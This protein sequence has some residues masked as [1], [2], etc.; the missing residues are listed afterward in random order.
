MAQ[1]EI[2]RT[3]AIVLRSL[4]YGETSQIVTLFTREKG[5]ITVMA[6]GARRT[7]S[8]FGATL[9]LMAYTQVVFYYKPG[10]NLQTLSESA[11]VEPLHRLN[12]SLEKISIGLRMVELVH[13]LLEKEDPQPSVFNLTQQTLRRLNA[14]DQRAA[15]LW[16]FFQ[17]R[18]ATQLGMAPS[19][20]RD[21]VNQVPERGGILDLESGAVLPPE[22]APRAG[23]RASRSALRAYAIFARAALDDVVR[24]RLRAAVRREV[25]DLISSYMRYQFE[26]AYPSTS[27]EVISQL[28]RAT[29]RPHEG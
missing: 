24:M 23:R 5:K 1:R 21:A 2:V 16:P 6:K 18:L 11:H 17:L 4:N 27:D 25:D 9:Q 29:R 13:A 14:V 15:N 26:S 19:V 20:Q 28:L 12:R 8:T 7:K 3:E 22:G 10:R